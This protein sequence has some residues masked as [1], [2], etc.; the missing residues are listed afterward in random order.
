MLDEA[1]VA[2]EARFG[3]DDTIV[4]ALLG[5]AAGQPDLQ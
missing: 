2:R 3:N 4:R 1:A 5:A